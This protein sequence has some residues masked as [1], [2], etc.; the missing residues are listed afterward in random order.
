M[1]SNLV[2]ATV[3]SSFWVVETFNPTIRRWTIEG[4]RNRAYKAKKLRDTLQQGLPVTSRIRV[5]RFVA[6]SEN[7]KGRMP[8][9]GT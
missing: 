6:E 7:P 3:H 5:R 1:S 9:E 4:W 8:R 2:G